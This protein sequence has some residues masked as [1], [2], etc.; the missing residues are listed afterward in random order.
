MET[1]VSKNFIK[2]LFTL[3]NPVNTETTRQE[4]KT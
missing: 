2:K 1:Y 3:R 4:V